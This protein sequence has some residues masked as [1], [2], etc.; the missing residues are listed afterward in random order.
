MRSVHECAQNG[1]LSPGNVSTFNSA[2]HVP[3]HKIRS[4]LTM[5]FSRV[6]EPSR[7]V[8]R[9]RHFGGIHYLL[10]F[11]GSAITKITAVK[12]QSNNRLNLSSEITSQTSKVLYTKRFLEVHLTNLKT[13]ST[14]FLKE[15]WII[16]VKIRIPTGLRVSLSFLVFL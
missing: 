14:K 9:C 4:N 11:M 2:F 1:A 13:K 15:K 3:H 7:L 12:T 5:F 6:L 10:I 8:E 16:A